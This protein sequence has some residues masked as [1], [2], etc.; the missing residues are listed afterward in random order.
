MGNIFLV[1]GYVTDCAYVVP[2]R[3]PDGAGKASQLNYY[4]VA[5]PNCLVSSINAMPRLGEGSLF[6]ESERQHTAIAVRRLRSRM[7][8]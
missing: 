2:K 8:R 4:S 1:W 6:L 7:T 5:S 3:L